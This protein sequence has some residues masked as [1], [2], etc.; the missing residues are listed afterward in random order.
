[1]AAEKIK[2]NKDE[3]VAVEDAFLSAQFSASGST[4]YIHPNNELPFTTLKC[5]LKGK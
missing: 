3:A 1:M 4:D 5:V 2:L